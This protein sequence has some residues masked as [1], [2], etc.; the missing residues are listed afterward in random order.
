MVFLF[1]FIQALTFGFLIYWNINVGKIG[2]SGILYL[3]ITTGVSA[4]IVFCQ[5][6]A[7]DRASSEG[8]LSLVMLT[9]RRKI[10]E[11]KSRINKLS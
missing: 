5:Q 3:I 11:E 8:L 9:I 2:V 6:V 1:A 7:L 10:K 4:V